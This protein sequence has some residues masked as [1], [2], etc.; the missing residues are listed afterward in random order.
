MA[1]SDVSFMM[2]DELDGSA[3][4]MLSFTSGIPALLWFSAVIFRTARSSVVSVLGEAVARSIKL[5]FSGFLVS[6]SSSISGDEGLWPTD[7]VSGQIKQRDLINQFMIRCTTD[8]S[9][10]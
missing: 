6:K 7:E 3:S 8:D 1:V 4:E 2:F 5:P 9:C 10:F